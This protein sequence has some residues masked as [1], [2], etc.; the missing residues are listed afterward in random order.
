MN[1]QEISFRNEPKFLSMQTFNLASPQQTILCRNF[2][3]LQQ[4]FRKLFIFNKFVMVN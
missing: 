4:M 2:M 3:S 1:G